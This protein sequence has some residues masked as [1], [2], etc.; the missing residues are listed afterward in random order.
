MSV[1]KPDWEEARQRMTDWWNGKKTDRAPASVTAP[2]PQETILLLTLFFVDGKYHRQGIG[3]K[4]FETV[5]K[6]SKQGKITVNSSPYAVG[7]Y[8]KL[9]FVPNG[10]EQMA[11]GMRFMPMTYIK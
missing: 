7:V 3:R 5:I 4:L 11:D 10:D 6:E 2:R 1:Y 8:K 9:G